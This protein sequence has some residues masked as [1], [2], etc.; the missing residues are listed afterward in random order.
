MHV[1]DCCL[2]F[3]IIIRLLIVIVCACVCMV[4]VFRFGDQ[5]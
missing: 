5:F 2:F 4:F 1:I 3:G